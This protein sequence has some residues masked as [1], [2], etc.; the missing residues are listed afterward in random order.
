[1]PLP[2]RRLRRDSWRAIAAGLALALASL[3]IAWAYFGLRA[4]APFGFAAMIPFFVVGTG[5][6]H[7]VERRRRALV[8]RLRELGW[9]ACTACAYPLD[10]NSTRC[11]ECGLGITANQAAG[12][13]LRCPWAQ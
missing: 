13:W 9:R 1:M 12:A 6:S 5:G 11:P 3:G 7:L 8:R 2:L 4:I 10:A